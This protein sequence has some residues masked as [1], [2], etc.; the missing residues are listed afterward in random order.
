MIKLQ[1][2][3]NLSADPRRVASK[4]GTEFTTF[5]VAVNGRRGADGEQRTTW[6]NVSAFRQLGEL[7]LQYLAKGR[8]V[9]VE[10]ELNVRPYKGKDGEARAD[11]GLTANNVEFLSS[12]NEAQQA[13][14]AEPAPMEPV[15]VDVSDLP[16]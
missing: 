3:G 6:V 1:I 14:T 11:I 12:R 16:F 4:N 7:C 13:E 10:G 8:K 9:Y 2:I 5:T 15:P